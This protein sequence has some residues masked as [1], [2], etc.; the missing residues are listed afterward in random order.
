MSI[1][2]ILV[3]VR[4]D[5]KGEGVLAHAAAIA[6]WH[7]AHIEA[8]HCR[9]QPKDMIPY[10]GILPAAL[11][12]QIETQAVE[13][14]NAEEAK[15]KTDFDALMARLGI[16]VV[17]TGAPP[18]D[19]PTAAWCEEPGK[20]ADV[21]KSHGR[22]VDLVAVAKPDR[23]R[24]LGV[25]TLRAALFNTGRPVLICPPGP[26]PQRLGQRV[27][28]AW[29]GS[30]EASRAVALALPLIHEAEEVIVL[31][32]GTDDHGA[33]GEELLRY[34][35]LCG[36]T[37]RREPIRAEANPGAAILTAA[38]ELARADLLVMGAYSHSH[39]HE[40]VFGGATQHVV[41]HTAIPVV[42]VH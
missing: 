1:V 40:T 41:D 6:R 2:K 8:V 4:G 15:L 42:M 5:G 9:A 27:A 14:A 13:L 34:L 20:Q 23:D 24:N 18:V 37:A 17:A 33:S 28:I 11:R 22:L 35:A 30:T 29:N 19:P 32:G 31:D 39:E 25:N 12:K 21:I 10:G 7:S 36:V 26:P 38:S 3:P 16:T